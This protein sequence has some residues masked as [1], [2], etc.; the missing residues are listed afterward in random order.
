M[1]ERRGSTDKNSGY[2][3]GR[4]CNSAKPWYGMRVN[5]QWTRMVEEVEALASDADEGNE[6]EAH[7][8]SACT[9]QGIIR[10]HD[11]TE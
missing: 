6:N 5:F 7:G 8:Q 9:C 3:C 10:V 1:L 4:D 11:N 2:Y